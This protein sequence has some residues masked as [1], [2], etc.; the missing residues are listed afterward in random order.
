MCIRLRKQPFLATIFI[1]GII[2]IF[3]PYP[4][5]GDST[6]W[7]GLLGCA[8]EIWSELRYPLLA[9]ALNLYAA[10][11]LP[12]LHDSWLHFGTGNANFFYAAT[13]VY[14]LGCGMAVTDVLGAAIRYRARIQAASPAQVSA[15]PT[16]GELVVIQQTTLVEDSDEDAMRQASERTAELKRI[17]RNRKIGSFIHGHLWILAAALT[18]AGIAW[19]LA[20]PIEDL[21]RG[22]FLDE[23]AIQPGQVTTYWNWD[24]VHVAD[25]LLDKL[26]KVQG[27]TSAERAHFIS[28][29]LGSLGLE[30]DT[31]THCHGDMCGETAYAIMTPP[32]ATACETVLLSANWFSLSG[33]PNL[34]GI[35]NLM[36]FARFLRGQN[37]WAKEFVFVFGDGYVEGLEAFLAAYHGRRMPGLV[38]NNFK[39]APQGVIWTALNI[40]YPGHSFSHLGLYYEGINGALPNQDLVN[41]VAHISQYT[42]GA[43]VRLHS[44][45]AD[46]PDLSVRVPFVPQEVTSK[47]ARNARHLVEDLRYAGLGNYSGAHGL[48]AEYR[49]DGL[50]LFAEPATGPHGFHALGIILESTARSMNNLLERLHASF[51]FFLFIRPGWFMKIGTYLP[52]TLL[53][54]AA[55]TFFGLKLWVDAGWAQRVS[56][57][58]EQSVVVWT[59]RGR[60]V[61]M[62]IGCLA[63]GL[64]L[65]T[66]GLLA[67][68]L[69]VKVADVQVAGIDLVSAESE[70]AMPA[71]YARDTRLNFRLFALAVLAGG[72][73]A[74]RT[75][76]C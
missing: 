10:I 48:F 62:A 8:P 25:V 3:K 46:L 60:D 6:I 58:K 45:S 52:S 20:L 64:G 17:Q 38:H 31:L 53:L 72:A 24:D 26:E 21:G 22:T 42:A 50:T 61:G 12:V 34:R 40:D 54:G 39:L 75:L 27:A 70:H 1:A 73:L 44:V 74:H 32:R 51:H 18:F 57:I 19:L 11:L 35:A 16:D 29:E 7:L 65:G 28:S 63:A 30:S 76:D 13:M 59:R 23:N 67:D 15:V 5:L 36:A 14:G 47:Y 68:K 41:T 37:H 69:L 4:T 43:P 55:A 66:L 49:I 33:G 2:A 9:F 56:T 71:P